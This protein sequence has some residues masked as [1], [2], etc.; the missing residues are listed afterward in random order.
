MT[1]EISCNTENIRHVSQAL[2][3]Q[4]AGEEVAQAAQPSSLSPS[5]LSRRSGASALGLRPDVTK[6][7]LGSPYSSQ[8][9]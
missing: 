6:A 9:G 7:T 5:G 2:A 1:G 8:A 3:A 4:V